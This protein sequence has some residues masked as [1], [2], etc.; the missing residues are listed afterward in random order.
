MNYLS[1]KEITY[2]KKTLQFNGAK[3]FNSLGHDFKNGLNYP[4]FKAKLKT[5]YMVKNVYVIIV[6]IS[7]SP[8]KKIKRR[9]LSYH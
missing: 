5:W 9:P 2:G 1:K 8:T 4:D 6:H 7:H 3:L